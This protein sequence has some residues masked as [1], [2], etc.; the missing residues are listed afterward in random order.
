MI[1]RNEKKQTKVYKVQYRKFF[2]FQLQLNRRNKLV[3]LK[4]INRHSFV[5]LIQT[6]FDKEKNGTE[7]KCN[8]GYNECPTDT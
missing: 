1:E 6:H 5:H 2:F 4:S 3:Q 7:N 8:Q